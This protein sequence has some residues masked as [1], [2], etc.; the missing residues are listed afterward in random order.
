MKKTVLVMLAAALAGCGAPEPVAQQPYISEKARAALPSGTD[1]MTVR[2][3]ED[4]CYFIVIEDELSGYL[5]QVKDTNGELVC[6]EV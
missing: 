1:L 2:R 5:S 4:G 3:R 6:D